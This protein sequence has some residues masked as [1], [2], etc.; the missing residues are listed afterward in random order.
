MILAHFRGFV[1][2]H[3][4]FTDL[5]SPTYCF[6]Q[7]TIP[8]FF[9]PTKLTYSLFSL[10][11]TDLF[12]LLFT[13]RPPGIVCSLVV[14]VFANILSKIEDVYFRED[15]D[16]VL[17]SSVSS[18]AYEAKWHFIDYRINRNASNNIL[19]F[20]VWTSWIDTDF[21]GCV[22]IGIVI[23]GLVILGIVEFRCSR[24]LP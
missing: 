17:C 11:E 20:V 2:I 6:V 1:D 5:K 19:D 21:G 14:S 13:L 4:S 8:T 12:P 23:I 7:M 24:T 16:G 10:E 18:P 9:S 3:L 22:I 15:I